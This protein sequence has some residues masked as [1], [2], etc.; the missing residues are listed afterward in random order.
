MARQ[1]L[2][3][4]QIRY[5][6]Q[7]GS[8]G[9]I[10]AAA[11]EL[12]IGQATL[13][14]NILKLERQLGVTLLVRGNRGILLTHAGETLIREGAALAD[15]AAAVMRSASASGQA[16]GGATLGLPPSL[17]KLIAVP[18]AETMRVEHPQIR[19]R[20]SEGL[21]GHILDWLVQDALDLGF[22]YHVP[23]LDL[24]EVVPFF[25]EPLYLMAAGDFL[26]AGVTGAAT[27]PAQTLAGLPFVV[28]STKH[29]A[30]RVL[31]RILRKHRIALNVVSE[32]DSHSQIVEML[33]RANA[34]AI[35]P[36]AAVLQQLHAGELVAIPLA[37]ELCQ[38]T[39]YSVRL[40]AKP[41]S[42]ASLQIEAS[43]AAIT[44]E[45]SVRYD[46]QLEFI[47][48]RAADRL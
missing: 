21:S 3:L 5:F 46:L 47:A 32:I 23:D 33:V 7:V 24:F 16:S 20:L 26:P 4:K 17:G 41:V 10:S 27:V 28:P 2:D 9:S 22:I 25:R 45:M 1:E 39:C 29:S 11:N 12:G 38:R 43:I 31:D 15:A 6:L 36:R 14:E 34:Y 19:L 35:L 37:D 8:A 42:A 40:R 18:L 44:R 13:S 30:R 48:G